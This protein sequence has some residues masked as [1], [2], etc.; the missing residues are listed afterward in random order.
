[1]IRHSYNESP[2]VC[3]VLN[4]ILL[5]PIRYQKRPA[6]IGCQGGFQADT[7]KWAVGL[8]PHFTT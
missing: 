4:P 8:T 5:N 3:Q 6:T 1:M 7:Q 2:V